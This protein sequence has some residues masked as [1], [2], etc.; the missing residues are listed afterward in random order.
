MKK[1]LSQL[2]IFALVFQVTFPVYAQNGEPETMIMQTEHCYKQA[3]ERF[4]HDNNIEMSEA[5]LLDGLKYLLKAPMGVSEKI[6]TD[7]SGVQL[8]TWASVAFGAVMLFSAYASIRRTRF[9]DEG[10]GG[11][12]AGIALVG[13]LT[14]RSISKSEMSEAE[15]F[16][17]KLVKLNEPSTLEGFYSTAME[18][19]DYDISNYLLTVCQR[20]MSNPDLTTMNWEE[21]LKKAQDARNLNPDLKFD[22]HLINSEGIIQFTQQTTPVTTH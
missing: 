7:K 21:F 18:L 1:G 8:G 17:A 11:F 14:M 16:K 22:G 20:A 9:N 10:L 2:L 5:E 6:S 13:M 12:F 15:E 19:N 3:A 4:A